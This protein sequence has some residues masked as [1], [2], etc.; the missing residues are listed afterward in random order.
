MIARS[1]ITGLLLAGGRA[2]RMGGIDKGLIPFQ[3]KPLIE[4]AIN[5][6]GPQVANL[7][8]NANRNQTVYSQY[9]YPIV[10]DE[11]QDYAGPLAGYLAGLKGCNTPYLMTAPCDSPLFPT[12]LVEVLAH[13]LEKQGSHIAYAS[14]QD[15]SGKIWAQPVF[16]LMKREVV[17]SLEQFLADGQRKIDRWFASQNACTTIFQNESAFANANTPDEL[18]QLEKFTN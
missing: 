17:D 7:V 4:H 6:L 9:G 18:A 1:E 10:A 13:T 16:C 14:S 12:D 2:L 11:N 5:R 15:P 3:G 8:I